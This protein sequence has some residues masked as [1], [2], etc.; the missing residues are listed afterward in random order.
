MKLSQT[1]LYY[2]EAQLHISQTIQ[3]RVGVRGYSNEGYICP[4]ENG[5]Y[6]YVKLG[7]YVKDSFGSSK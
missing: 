4:F 5:L 1:F 7:V 3:N 6:V 2:S